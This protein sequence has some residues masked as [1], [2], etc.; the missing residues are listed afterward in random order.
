M[1]K[2]SL[3]CLL[4]STEHSVLSRLV[5]CSAT[6]LNNT[7]K[8]DNANHCGRRQKESDLFFSIFFRGGFPH[9]IFCNMHQLFQKKFYVKDKYIPSTLA[10]LLNSEESNMSHLRPFSLLCMQVGISLLHYHIG[11][12]C[13]FTL[14]QFCSLSFFKYVMSILLLARQFNEASCLRAI[15]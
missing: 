7:K 14:A 12:P 5:K 4:Y 13:F 1:F 11:C 9:L 8:L 6:I 2:Q 15:A 10:P 3:G